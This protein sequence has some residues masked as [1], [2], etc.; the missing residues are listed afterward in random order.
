PEAIGRL[1]H[2]DFGPFTGYTVE[3]TYEGTFGE[4]VAEGR[5][6]A[7]AFVSTR[8]GSVTWETW[9]GPG[10]KVTVTSKVRAEDE[11]AAEE[12]GAEASVWE[13]PEAGFRLA[14]A[15]RRGVSSSVRLLV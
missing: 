6:E 8:N 12:R 3:R 5:A 9:D 7:S 1:F 13:T 10:Y 2:F 14:A 4:D 15:D 11:D